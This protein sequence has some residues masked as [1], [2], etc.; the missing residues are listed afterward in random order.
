MLCYIVT[1]IRN[2]TVLWIVQNIFLST[3][4]KHYQKVQNKTEA[5][6]DGQ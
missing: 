4:F 6:K 2:E 1:S 5:D 3:M